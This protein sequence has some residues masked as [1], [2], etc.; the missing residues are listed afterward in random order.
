MAAH[1]KLAADFGNQADAVVR[2]ARERSQHQEKP[3]KS[4]DRVRESLTFS[5][6]KNFERESVVDERA[7]IRD[8]L[9][10]GMGDITYTQIRANLDARMASGE[11]QI[12]DDLRAFP[13]ASSR[14]RK[15]SKQNMRFSSGCVRV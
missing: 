8:G 14:P 2:A 15:P 7:L 10:R 5:R 11:F 9:R 12:V 1:R 13:A 3:L 4:L 6:G